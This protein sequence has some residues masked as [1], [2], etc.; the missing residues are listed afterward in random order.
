M[1]SSS[2]LL[3]PAHTGKNKQ[4]G[5]QPHMVAFVLLQSGLQHRKMWVLVSRGAVTVRLMSET[6]CTLAGSVVHAHGMGELL[7]MPC[8]EQ[9]LP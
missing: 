6:F 3:F 4:L 5:H 2:R 9:L 7:R 8:A 1:H